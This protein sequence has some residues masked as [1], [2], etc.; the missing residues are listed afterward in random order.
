VTALPHAARASRAVPARSPLWPRAPA[1]SR[2]PPVATPARARRRAFAPRLRGHS[3]R[4]GPPCQCRSVRAALP[5]GPS[6]PAGQAGCVGPW[7]AAQIP[8]PRT[9]PRG[10]GRPLARHPPPQTAGRGMLCGTPMKSGAGL[11]GGTRAR[12]SLASAAVSRAAAVSS[13]TCRPPHPPPTPT[14]IGWGGG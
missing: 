8:T 2:A 13:R 1:G 7:A 12:A 11:G 5:R 6:R 14:R 9:P 4:P 10:A 3:A